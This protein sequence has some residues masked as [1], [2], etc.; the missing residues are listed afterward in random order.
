MQDIAD[1]YGLSLDQEWNKELLPH[2]GRHPNE[3]HKFVLDGMKRAAREAGKNK[4]KFLKLFDKY[5]K[6]PVRKNPDLLRKC[7]WD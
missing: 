4:D 1:Q 7:G 5:V 3:Y 2:L 6:D